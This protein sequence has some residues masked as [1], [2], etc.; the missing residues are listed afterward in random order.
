MKNISIK[1][2]VGG[3]FKLEATNVRTGKKRLLADWFP[4][5]ITNGGL[6]QIGNSANWLTG[7]YVG[8]GNTAPSFT[9]TQLA[10]IV[11]STTDI[12]G[13]TASVNASSPYYGSRINTYFY[14]AGVATGTLA[15]IGVGAIATALFSRALILD[16]V[17]NPTTVTVLADEA[18]TAFYEFRNYPP[19]T[20]VTGSVT[21]S[22]T[23]YTFT[24]RAANAGTSVWEPAQ[25]G[26]EDG[27]SEMTIFAG[28]IGALTAG[29]A[30]ASAAESSG[31]DP[32]YTPGQLLNQRTSV[33]GGAI[34]NFGG[35]ESMLFT[36]GQVN[37]SLGQIQVGLSAAIPKDS[38]HSVTLTVQ[39]SWAR[40]PV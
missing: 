26:D 19:L 34:G 35:I 6:D 25:N 33:F 14:A 32:A 31:A 37:G 9:D 30:G 17:G 16:G 10:A 11:A 27:P 1:C 3:F 22:G 28:A 40:G 36:C 7:C 8:S 13:S 21:I 2:G 5:L 24:A 15:E 38:T 29:P 4:N 20:D 18:L 39:K 12:V 23:S